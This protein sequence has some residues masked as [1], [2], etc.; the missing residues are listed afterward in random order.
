MPPSISNVAT[1]AAA[2]AYQLHGGLY[3]SQYAEQEPGRV[4]RVDRHVDEQRVGHL[5]PEPTE[6][7]RP[8]E[9][10]GE[11]ADRPEVVRHRAQREE[12]RVPPP[13]L[14][15]HEQAARHL[16]RRGER[17]GLRHRLGHRLLA[18]HVEPGEEGGG[19]DGV[20]GLRHG[21]VDHRPGAGLARERH[22]VRAH[23]HGPP[24]RVGGGLRSGRVDVGDPGQLDVRGCLD[25][26]APRPAH[27]ARAGEDDPKGVLEAQR[28]LQGRSRTSAGPPR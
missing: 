3:A 10:G 9:L 25:G 6:P 20:V 21:R 22:H 8:E 15:H 14:A 5:V 26:V 12:L 13:R 16:R 28:G 17:Q 19:R 4:E 27:A 24:E 18:E 7:R 2:P 11:R 1:A 23:R